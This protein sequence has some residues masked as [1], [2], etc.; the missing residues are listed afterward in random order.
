MNSGSIGAS[1][2][3]EPGECQHGVPDYADCIDCLKARHRRE[4]EAADGRVE[5]LEARVAD[6]ER[7]RMGWERLARWGVTIEPLTSDAG[8]RRVFVRCG[9]FVAQSKDEATA[10]AGMLARAIRGNWETKR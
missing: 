3:E 5:R 2:P 6:L 8:D 1:G 10:W 4:I 9:G 7:A